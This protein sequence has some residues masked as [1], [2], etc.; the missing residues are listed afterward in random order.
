MCSTFASSKLSFSQ[1]ANAFFSL[2]AAL[3]QPGEWKEDD[4]LALRQHFEP[5][6]GELAEFAEEVTQEWFAAQED[7][8]KCE[9]AFAKLFLG[10]FEIMA[11]P[12]ASTYLDPDQ[13]LMGPVSFYASE[14]YAAAGLEQA[15]KV[16]EIPD[17]IV[18][19]MEF[20]YYLSFELANAG[21]PS[22]LAIKSRFWSEHLGVWMPKMAELISKADLHPFYNSLAKLI[23]GFA[24]SLSDEEG[25]VVQ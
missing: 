16:R 13:R 4:P 17:H 21:N 7:L 11:S 9:V 10:P 20:M 19:E 22:L 24:F 5:F 3:R 2:A 25:A 1:Q 12:Y 6:G 23:R 15:G 14:A 8:E 18:I